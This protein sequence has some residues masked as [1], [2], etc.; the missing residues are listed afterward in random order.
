MPGWTAGGEEITMG[1]QVALRFQEESKMNRFFV[2]VFCL[3]M[4]TGSFLSGSHASAMEDYI[5][6]RFGPESSIILDTP[7]PVIFQHRTHTGQAGLACVSCHD[8]LFVMQRGLT[9]KNAQTMKSL[10]EG[11]SCGACHDGRTAFAAD[12][13]CDAC[14]I[15]LN[16][17]KTPAPDSHADTHAIH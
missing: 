1:C 15:R 17:V 12:T 7:V 6:K 10:A 13:H 2:N 16:N 14:H 3:T 8:E 9:P 11:K 5:V 4:L